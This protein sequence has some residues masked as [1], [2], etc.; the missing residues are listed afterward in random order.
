MVSK[1]ISSGDF[2]LSFVVVVFGVYRGATDRYKV[3]NRMARSTEH[4]GSGK[5]K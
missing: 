2:I 5:W 4:R 1:K 3:E